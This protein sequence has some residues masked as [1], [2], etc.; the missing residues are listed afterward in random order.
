M[1]IS[2]SKNGNQLVTRAGPVSA[3]PNLDKLAS[4]TTPYELQPDDNPGAT[5]DVQPIGFVY[6][7]YNEVMNYALSYGAAV[8]AASINYSA[9]AM[10]GY[11]SNGYSS[12]FLSYL[13]FTGITPK[14]SAPGFDSQLPS[15]SGFNA[16]TWSFASR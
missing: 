11:N 6:A 16:S 14:L 4:F 7:T 3:F 2:E 8:D 12:T 15:L 10:F 5:V 13:G 1:I 9:T